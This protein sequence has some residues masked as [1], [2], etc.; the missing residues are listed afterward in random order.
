MYET[1]RM[2]QGQL[3]S[4]LGGKMTMDKDDEEEKLKRDNLPGPGA[5][6][7]SGKYGRT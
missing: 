2:P 7:D 4:M 5:Y 6:F 3:K 1:M